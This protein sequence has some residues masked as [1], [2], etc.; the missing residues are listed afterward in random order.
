MSRHASGK[1]ENPFNPF[2]I[3]LYLY[4]PS[5]GAN[6]IINPLQWERSPNGS[7]HPGHLGFLKPDDIYQ[8]TLEKGP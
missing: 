2:S 4:P 7:S 5:G 8:L 3:I 6:E 1:L